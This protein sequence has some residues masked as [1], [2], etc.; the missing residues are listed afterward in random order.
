[1]TIWSALCAVPALAAGAGFI[2]HFLRR[3]GRRETVLPGDPLTVAWRPAAPDLPPPP[4]ASVRP[5]EMSGEAT[6][7][8]DL[9]LFNRQL[10]AALGT[11]RTNLAVPMSTVE[12]D[13]MDTDAVRTAS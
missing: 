5:L 11:F 10:D 1:M 12:R 13:L 2:V 7:V 4:P 6:I 9:T 3:G 8:A